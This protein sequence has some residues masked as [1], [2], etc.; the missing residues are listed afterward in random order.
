MTVCFRHRHTGPSP[1]VMVWGTTGYTFRSPLVRTNGILN[2]AH[3]ISGML[4]SMALPFI[5]AL[6]DPTF[7]QNNARP[8]VSGIVRTFLDT[9]NIHLLL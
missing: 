1:G 3:Y 8:Y 9:E 2:S 4:R 6:R 7:Q 5:R